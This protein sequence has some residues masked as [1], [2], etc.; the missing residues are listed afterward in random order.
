MLSLPCD[1]CAQVYVWLEEDD[2]VVEDYRTFEGH[3]EDITHMAAFPDKQVV[4]LF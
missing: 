3:R 1:T 4:A 2:D